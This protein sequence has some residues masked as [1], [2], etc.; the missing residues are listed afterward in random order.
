MHEFMK[1]SPGDRVT[2]VLLS[3][4]SGYTLSMLASLTV[5]VSLWGLN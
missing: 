1:L 4:A 5:K 3:L 2:L